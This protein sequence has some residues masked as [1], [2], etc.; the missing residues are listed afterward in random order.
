MER[1]PFVLRFGQET[2]QKPFSDAERETLLQ[3]LAVPATPATPAWRR[4]WSCIRAS[5]DS[6]L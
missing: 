4:S 6:A 3:T 2:A 5:C 1:L